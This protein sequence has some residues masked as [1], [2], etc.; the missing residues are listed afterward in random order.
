MFKKT[1][2]YLAL[3]FLLAVSSSSVDSAPP[4]PA[5]PNAQTGI[6]ERM[7][8]AQGKAVLSLNLNRLRGNQAPSDQETKLDTFP[9]A[10]GPNSFF[11]IRV[12]NNVLRGPEAGSM[13]LL[14]GNSS[15][16]PEPLNA[17]SNQLVI[18]KNPS[19]EPFALVVRDG[20]TGFLFFNIEGHLY[21]YDAAAH[22]LQINGG[23]LL[24]STELANKLGRPA[25]AGLVAGEISITTTV[26]PIEVTT[27]VN[28]VAQSSSLPARRSGAGDGPDGGV[29]GPDII[30]GDLPSMAQFGA[31][32]SQVGLGVGT[33]SCNNGSV[34]V[35]WFELPNTNHNVIPQNL[36]RMS[37]GA[38]NNDRFEQVGQ[39]W[40]KHAVFALQDNACGFGCTPA[41]NGQHLGVGCSDPYD[42]G[43]NASQ[44]FLGSRAWVNPFTGVF[45]S[46]SANH[47]GHVHTGQSHMILVEQNDL[48]TT[49]NPGAS[50]YAEA[51]YVNPQEYNWCQTHPGQCNM[52]NNASYRRFSVSGTSSFTFTPVG[53]TVRMAPAINAW[54][55]ATINPIEPVP[56]VDG[57]AFIASKVTGPVGGF[58]HYEYAI[59]NQNLDRGIQ[60]FSVPVG[61]ASVV[62]NPGFHAPANHP[63]WANDGTQGSAGYSNAAW[64]FSSTSTLLTWHS[65]TFAQN[66]NANALRWGTLY[67]FRFD[68][69]R[70]PLNRSGTVGF[71]KTGT[72]WGAGILVPDPFLDCDS[73]PTPTPVTPTPTATPTPPSTPSP[74]P[75][76]SPTPSGTPPS[77]PTPTATPPLTPTPT[78]TAPPS[79]SPTPAARPINISTRLFVQ[80]G[81]NVGIGGFI[82]TGTAPKQVLLR[83]IGPSLIPSGITNAL[84]DPVLELHGPNGF[85]TIINDNWRDNQEVEI[86]A[87][88]AAPGNDLEA[89]ILATLAPGNYTAIV[90]GK[91]N[92][93]GV[94]LVEAYDLGTA[95]TSKLANISTRAFCGTGS[96]IIIAGFILGNPPQAGGSDRSVLR[97][98]GPSL[99][100]AG[101][102][103][104][105]ADPTL[106][107]RDSNGTLLVSN[108]DWQDNPSQAAEIIAAG[109]A[110]TNELEAAIAVTLSPGIYTALLAGLNDGTGVGL[111]E[112]YDRGGP[113]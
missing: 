60:S 1:L 9:F 70:P 11:T 48:N 69:N 92:T 26:Y 81:D 90:A 33:T 112:V 19:S 42:A 34:E 76:A 63:G 94:A 85:T 57:R 102:P 77:T 23:R 5:K 101:V 65:E 73:S 103:D 87:T 41:S 45:P 110:P 68:S 31:G 15:V 13:G 22:V 84:A 55:G 47:A 71:F 30:V 58:W 93:T 18:E 61:C 35:D 107:L 78:A 96:D 12:F 86:F 27:I 82:V 50:Y 56:G 91:N 89:A 6:L 88:G 99:G 51:M 59:F 113:P 40:M 100:A 44:D 37:G 10:V 97:G 74:T 25:D 53:I 109:L 20:K 62:T 24:I 108:N 105:L 32:G 14:W 21:D 54:S 64:T 98:L 43:L 83:A 4:L 75:P 66:P 106:E 16:L 28:S 95:A 80:P 8:V 2:I 52:Y 104:A 49:L 111:V 38:N 46:E 7:I 29:P 67:N 17:S 3:P 79:P 36:Y 72:S 39:S